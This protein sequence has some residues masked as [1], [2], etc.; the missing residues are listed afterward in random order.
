MKFIK[1]DIE[2]AYIIEPEPYCDER[3]KFSRIFCS[4]EFKTVNIDKEFVQVNHSITNKK[5]T[6]RG[7]HMQ[8]PPKLESK[9]IKCI[10]GSVFDILADLRKNS[11]TYLKWTAVE[12]SKENM[13]MIYIPEGC[14]HGFQ[15]LEN[16]CELIYF[17]SEFYSPDYE[18]TIHFGCKE[19]NIQ[20]PLEITEI[21]G[22]DS[23]GLKNLDNFGV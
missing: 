14:A 15:T 23:N 22:K 3:G 8:R 11:P 7:F 12:L 1:A 21:S 17:H 19:L 18:T 16:N 10:N 20:L 5:G 4:R 2:G 9:L 6:F 13:K